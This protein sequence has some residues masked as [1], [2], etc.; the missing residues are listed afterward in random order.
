MVNI[1]LRQ[2][3]EICPIVL[4]WTLHYIMHPLCLQFQ[5]HLTFPFQPFHLFYHSV[6]C[7]PDSPGVP[8]VFFLYFSICFMFLLYPSSLLSSAAPCVSL[9][10]TAAGSHIVPNLSFLGSAFRWRLAISNN[11]RLYNTVVTHHY[12]IMMYTSIHH[13]CLSTMV[14][15]RQWS[16]ANNSNSN[17]NNTNNNNNNSKNNSNNNKQIYNIY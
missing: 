6:Y 5:I 15:W 1:F 4:R 2:A 16:A 14:D 9:W 17:H 3:I 7:N 11:V 12:R 13:C 10:I 8:T